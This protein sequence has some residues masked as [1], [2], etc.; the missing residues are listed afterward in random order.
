MSTRV[1]VCVA[2]LPIRFGPRLVLRLEERAEGAR[3]PL[4]PLGLRVST[5]RD[6]ADDLLR[7]RARLGGR[8]R[9]RAA[10]LTFFPRP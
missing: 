8:Q 9:V 6:V 3:P 7:Q 5:V 10:E 4:S 2:R 1:T